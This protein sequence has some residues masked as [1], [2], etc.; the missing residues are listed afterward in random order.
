MP[1]LVR[2]AAVDTDILGY[3]IPKGAT[4]MCNVQFMMEPQEVKE[5]VRSKTCRAAKEKWD[6]GFQM[7][8]LEAFL[9]ERWLTRDENG[10]EVLD[11]STLTRLAF[12]LGPRGYFGMFA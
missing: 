5:E 4:V 9:P 10:R 12:G 2:V 7:R 6:R 3:R 8:N 1:L 11:G